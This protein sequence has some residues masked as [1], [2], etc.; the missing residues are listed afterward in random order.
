M[1][2]R[3]K[4]TKFFGNGGQ[5]HKESTGRGVVLLATV[6]YQCIVMTITKIKQQS[7]FEMQKLSFALISSLSSSCG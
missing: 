4:E 3:R 7:S 2:K 1:C 6:F 5:L